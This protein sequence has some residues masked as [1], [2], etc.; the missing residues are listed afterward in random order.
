[1]PSNPKT[2]FAMRGSLVDVQGRRIPNFSCSSPRNLEREIN[3]AIQ[4]VSVGA[5]EPAFFFED[6][7]SDGS[8]LVEPVALNYLTWNIDLTQSLWQKGSNV[9]VQG[10]RGPAP[11]NSFLG[12][13]VTWV[14]GTGATQK[15]LRTI[16]DLPGAQTYQVTLFLQ[17]TGG[18]CGPND[19][20]RITGGVVGTVSVPMSQLNDY[21]GKYRIVTL[22]FT[23]VGTQ[24]T[25]PSDPTVGGYT[26][27]A[28]TANTFTVSGVGT[29]AANALV[30]GQATFTVGTGTYL[31]TANTAVTSGSVTVTVSTNTLVTNGVTTAGRASF[32]GPPTQACTLE[33]SCESTFSMVWGGAQLEAGTFRT[34]MIYQQ[35]ERTPRAAS[36]LEF[37]SRDNPFVDLSSFGVFGEL[38]LWRGD[39]NLIDFGDFR[40]AIANGSLQVSAGATQLTDPDPFPA[41]FAKF[42][43]GVSAESSSLSLFVNGVLKAKASLSNL[44]PT[45]KPV[46]FTSGGVRLWKTIVCSGQTLLDGQPS[47][48]QLAA[49]ELL[50]VFNSTTPVVNSSLI[51]TST[52]FNLPTVTV[53]AP[54]AATA[55]STISAINTGTKVATVGSGTGFAVNDSISVVRGVTGSASQTIIVYAT[56]TAVSG[57][58]IT[59]D[60]VA[61]VAVGDRLVK[62]NVS[63]PGRAFIRFPFVPIDEQ[64]ITVVDTGNSRV[65]VSSA[66]AFV[67]NQRAIVRNR[68]YQ[69]VAE[70]TVTAVDTINNRITVN[71][72]SL[73]AV[74]HL[75][76][77]PLSE[78]RIDPQ[79]YTVTPLN[80]VSGV[81]I[82]AQ[83]GRAQNGIVV[84]NSNPWEVLVT[85]RIEVFL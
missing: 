40:L 38:R 56:V 27:T 64:S 55:N 14:S 53:P 49:Q 36:V 48:G 60:T 58:N 65:T 19:V 73:L 24:P 9:I 52:A 12:D 1:M 80:Q 70:V 31:I 47:V 41:T 33:L 30:G 79:N 25:L 20:I 44:K 18:R 81:R 4:L 15:L 84:E 46:I 43:V 74:G 71:D 77:Q 75:I 29:L 22:S 85:F 42:F 83:N 8:F 67:V 45:S 26:I 32:Q 39:G 6:G 62:G 5:F 66:L 13:A 2:K 76:S 16:T 72:V 50:A 34:S 3:N 51:A 17:P 37:Q 54:T 63:A 68:F 82:A 61:G 7:P 28:V 11:D 57:N 23:T 10:D 78:T 21:I 69:D 59:L 35:A